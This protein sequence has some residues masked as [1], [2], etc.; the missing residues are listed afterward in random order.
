MQD[1]SPAAIVKT[2]SLEFQVILRYDKAY[3]DCFDE[4][5]IHFGVGLGA[6]NLCSTKTLFLHDNIQKMLVYV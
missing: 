6:P 1:V 4:Y 5:Y 2:E 3:K